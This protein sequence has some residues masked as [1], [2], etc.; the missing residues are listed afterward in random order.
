M[1]REVSSVQVDMQQR[2]AE[3]LKENEAQAQNLRDARERNMHFSARLVALNA[4]VAQLTKQLK[5]SQQ[6]EQALSSDLEA[7]KKAHQ[8]AQQQLLQAQNQVAAAA[9]AVKDQGPYQ[10]PLATPSPSHRSMDND[11]A[12][13][14]YPGQSSGFVPL[15]CTIGIAH[16]NQQCIA[17]VSQRCRSKADLLCPQRHADMPHFITQPTK[18]YVKTNDSSACGGKCH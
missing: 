7:A 4:R 15:L 1:Q 2:L 18:Q 6:R 14:M 16:M 9:Q 3:A 11:G 8:E 12:S 17:R 5:E 10:G 13:P